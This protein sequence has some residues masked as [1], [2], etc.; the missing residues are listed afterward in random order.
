MELE[1][2]GEEGEGGGVCVG[3]GVG[4]GR[5]FS[6]WQDAGSDAFFFYSVLDMFHESYCPRVKF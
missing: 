4:A 2:G 6:F 5:D 1:R 3:V